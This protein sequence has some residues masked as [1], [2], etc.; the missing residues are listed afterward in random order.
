M[1]AANAVPRKF[2]ATCPKGLEYLL[3]DEL[4]ALGAAD[5]HEALAGVHFSGGLEAGYRACLWSR[6]ASRVL[7]PI[8]EFAVSD[9]D[10]LYRG[11]LEVDWSAHFGSD[12][13][14][15][16]DAVGSTQ[17]ITHTQFAALR[18]IRQRPE[19]AAPEGREPLKAAGRLLR[20]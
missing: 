14:F 3:V 5:A 12:A 20:G 19:D 16:V 18:G 2:F 11:A 1:N 8:A 6:L 10:A 7:M 13:T 9:G 17:G 15:A 4:K